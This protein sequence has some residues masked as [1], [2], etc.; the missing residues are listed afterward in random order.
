MIKK[1]LCVD[2]KWIVT[3]LLPDPLYPKCDNPEA[4]YSLV[5]G[6]PN[7]CC[8]SLRGDLSGPRYRREMTAGERQRLTEINP[9]GPEGR[10][11]E[12]KAP[13]IP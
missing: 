2:C 5:T 10:W 11:F 9:C 13:A 1:P 6:E 8:E 12:A 4:P 7:R 3:G